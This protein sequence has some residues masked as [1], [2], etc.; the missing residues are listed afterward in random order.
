MKFRVVLK[1]PFGTI[2]GEGEVTMNAGSVFEGGIVQDLVMEGS[3]MTA[4]AKPLTAAEHAEQ[5]RQIAGPK[6]V[7]RERMAWFIELAEV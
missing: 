1:D 3:T 6:Y 7:Q 2:A 5:V 4:V